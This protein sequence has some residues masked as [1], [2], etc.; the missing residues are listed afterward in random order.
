MSRQ[1]TINEAMPT[2]DLQHLVL[3]NKAMLDAIIDI[4]QLVQNERPIN[5]PGTPPTERRK[6]VDTCFLNIAYFCVACKGHLDW[7]FNPAEHLKFEK[8][9]QTMKIL[10]PT[11]TDDGQVI[12][13]DESMGN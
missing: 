13:F 4:R 5:Y 10:W 1:D 6:T 7:T 9:S 2:S 8:S 12:F 3:A 11:T